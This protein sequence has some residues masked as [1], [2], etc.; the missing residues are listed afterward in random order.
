MEGNQTGWVV[1][2]TQQ[3]STMQKSLRKGG[4]LKQRSK[5]M[6]VGLR[7]LLV[8]F[9]VEIA[10]SQYFCVY[11]SIYMISLLIKTSKQTVYSCD[12]VTIQVRPTKLQNVLV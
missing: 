1:R 6:S 3:S 9:A 2:T 8:S 7:H 10:A 5:T 11:I 4:I 12:K